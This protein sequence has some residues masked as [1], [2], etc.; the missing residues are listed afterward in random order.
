MTLTDTLCADADP[1]VACR[2]RRLLAGESERSPA[3]RRLR[4][5]IETSAMAQDLLRGLN[6]ERWSPYR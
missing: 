1:V 6:M 2:A 3:M 5:K 4:R